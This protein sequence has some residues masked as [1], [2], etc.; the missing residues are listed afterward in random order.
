[1]PPAGWSAV[2]SILLSLDSLD[3]FGDLE[4]L[5]CAEGM[6]L[7]WLVQ[8]VNR[9]QGSRSRYFLFSIDMAQAI[10]V[11]HPRHTENPQPI[12]AM[13]PSVLR[14]V[15]E[16]KSAPSKSMRVAGGFAQIRIGANV[17]GILVYSKAARDR[18]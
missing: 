15:E 17:R 7:P 4:K 18:G 11:P 9:G 5:S 14:W 1:M 8:L 10:P 16:L 3:C 2:R 12:S 6:Q 13:G